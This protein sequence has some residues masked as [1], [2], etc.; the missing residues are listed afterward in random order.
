[1][2]DIGLHGF[3][4]V[5]SFVFHSVFVHLGIEPFGNMVGTST[6]FIV[7]TFNAGRG[8]VEVRIINPLGTPEQVM[9]LLDLTTKYYGIT[10]NRFLIFNL[11]LNAFM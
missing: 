2:E 4:H 5:Y 7:E 6:H 11:S 1:M 8:D 10:M 3:C 9:D